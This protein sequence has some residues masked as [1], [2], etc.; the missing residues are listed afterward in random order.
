MLLTSLLNERVVALLVVC[1]HVIQ[2]GR[3]Q[4]SHISFEL[5]VFPLSATLERYLQISIAQPLYTFV[6]ISDISKH[7]LG[8][9]VINHPA[10]KL[11]LNRQLLVH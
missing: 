3:L 11:T 7:N 5:S 8:I 4:H 9:Q 1:A 10:H 2:L 6:P